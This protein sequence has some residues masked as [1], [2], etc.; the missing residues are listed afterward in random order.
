MRGHSFFFLLLVLLRIVSSQPQSTDWGINDEHLFG[1]H[2]LVLSLS[3]QGKQC[4]PIEAASSQ[5][6]DT[7][8][9]FI[10]GILMDYHLSLVAYCGEIRLRAAGNTHACSRY[11]HSLARG[12]F[13]HAVTHTFQSHSENKKMERDKF[14]EID[15]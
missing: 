11:H 14:T 1:T 4:Y 6:K 9:V 3:M 8:L 2:F 10:M 15:K 12:L 5:V 13:K 7:S